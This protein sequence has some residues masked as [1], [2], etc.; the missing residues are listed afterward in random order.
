MPSGRGYRRAWGLGVGHGGLY[1]A[2]TQNEVWG[3]VHEKF[4]YLTLKSVP[5]VNL[6]VPHFFDCGKNEFTKAL[7][8]MLV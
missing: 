8:A 6:S 2:P 7:S 4:L 5:L 1:V 3:M